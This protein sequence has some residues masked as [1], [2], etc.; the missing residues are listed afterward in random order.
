MA[1]GDAAKRSEGGFPLWSS[2]QE[3]QQWPPCTS[4]TFCPE[5]SPCSGGG[6]LW[7]DPE[8][9]DGAFGGSLVLSRALLLPPAD[10]IHMEAE[11]IFLISLHLPFHVTSLLTKYEGR[12]PGLPR[13]LFF[14]VLASLIQLCFWSWGGELVTIAT[15][16][17]PG[18]PVTSCSA[19]S[20]PWVGQSVAEGLW[21]RPISV[22][23]KQ[24][25]A[26]LMGRSY[27]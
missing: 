17:G 21:G 12:N 18:P 8:R 25:G 3:R 27:G 9:W 24:W 11:S 2:L 22:A 7:L 10:V 19:C 5:T 13:N 1:C 14:S 26:V 23:H 6:R 20:L 4:S 15:P 16:P